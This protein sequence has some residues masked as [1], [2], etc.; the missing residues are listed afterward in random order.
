MYKCER[1]KEILDLLS[2]NE[3]ATVDY[4]AKKNEHQPIEH[5]PRSEKSGG[6][7]I[8]QS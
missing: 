8:G 1:E 5:P 6:S 2:E 3:Y 4:L 7:R